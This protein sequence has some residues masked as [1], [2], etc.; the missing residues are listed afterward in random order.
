MRWDA[1][2]CQGEDAII[3]EI[4][5]ELGLST[6]LLSKWFQGAVVRRGDDVL[7]VECH[8]DGIHGMCDP[9]ECATAREAPLT[10]SVWGSGQP[11]KERSALERARVL[12]SRHPPPYS[13][14][15]CKAFPSDPTERER[16]GDEILTVLK[17]A[18]KTVYTMA[19]HGEF[20]AFNVRGQW[21][22]R[23]TGIGAWM[24]SQVARTTKKTEAPG[25][26]DG[27]A[28]SSRR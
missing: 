19:Q 8:Y 23:R 21:R 5:K 4:A 7:A 6:G 12:S 9:P 20:P 3:R 18:A 26:R 24:A 16:M 15:G 22:F 1:F 27:P 28:S 17:V 10:R 2:A 13:G 25:R 14:N 11:T